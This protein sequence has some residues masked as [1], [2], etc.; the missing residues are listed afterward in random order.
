MCPLQQGAEE[1]QVSSRS[2]PAV[3]LLPLAAVVSGLEP[4][5]DWSQYSHLPADDVGRLGGLGEAGRTPVH[6][7]STELPAITVFIGENSVVLT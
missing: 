7:G 6:W 4:S 5:P 3:D 1:T 2:C